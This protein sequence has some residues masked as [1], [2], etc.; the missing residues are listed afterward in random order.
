MPRPLR[1]C[2][3]LL[4]AARVSERAPTVWSRLRVLRQVQRYRQYEYRANSNLVLT[5]D[6]HRPR[7]DEPSGE[8]ESLKEHLG[9]TKFGDRVHYG[10][11]DIQGAG[12]KRKSD[13]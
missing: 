10:K 13:K 7:S 1:P 11:P 8:P 2:P 6:T 3:A 4:A 12:Q 5:T 9:G